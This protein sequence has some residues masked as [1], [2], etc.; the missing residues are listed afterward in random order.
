MVH[1]TIKINLNC[2]TLLK[3]YHSV[4]YDKELLAY[5]NVF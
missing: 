2:K 5:T 3:F 1:K 4:A